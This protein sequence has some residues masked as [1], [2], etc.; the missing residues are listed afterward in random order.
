MRAG[1]GQRKGM[2]LYLKNNKI[3][4][5]FNKKNRNPFGLNQTWL[6][7]RL[8]QTLQGMFKNLARNR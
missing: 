4:V 1:F 3:F 5:F 8:A 2:H 7:I 6:S